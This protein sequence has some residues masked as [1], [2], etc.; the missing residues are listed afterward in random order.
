MDTTTH[1]G[2][3]EEMTYSHMVGV[4]RERTKAEQALN[5]LR[6]ACFQETELTVYDPHPAEEPADSST[7]VLVHVLA[8]G[9]EQE[10]VAIL[11]S[12]GAN[13]ADLPLGTDLSHGSLTGAPDAQGETHA[14]A[15]GPFESFFS[16]AKAPGHPGDISITDNPS[17]PHG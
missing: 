7:R 2:T 16:T 10:A 8:E 4:F 12:H 11:V 5:E 15:A 13:N 1:V 9:R 14:T 17:T 6:Q 3:H